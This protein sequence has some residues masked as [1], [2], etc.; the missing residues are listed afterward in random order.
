M[1]AKEKLLKIYS[2]CSLRKREGVYFILNPNNQILGSGNTVS[3][4]YAN[5][6]DQLPKSLVGFKEQ[7]DQE[8]ERRVVEGLRRKGF[9]FET[10][11]QLKEFYQSRCSM[12]T[13]IYIS[14]KNT[15]LVDEEPFLIH[16]YKV[17]L[18]SLGKFTFPPF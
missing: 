2:N 15:Y 12:S 5:A 14:T 7:F 9:T 8:V 13:S 4:A 18:P 1:K 10:E 6:L 16:E 3:N 11:E 17:S